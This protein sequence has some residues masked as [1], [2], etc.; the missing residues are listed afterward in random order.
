MANTDVTPSQTE[1]TKDNT[2]ENPSQPEIAKVDKSVT[3]NVTKQ[4]TKYTE[5]QFSE[6]NKYTE[7]QS[8]DNSSM[9]TTTEK[10]NH[11]VH[12]SSHTCTR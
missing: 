11:T 8:S 4:A 5:Q 3:S 10:Y 6:A 9:S 2:D 1:I 7:Q 12:P